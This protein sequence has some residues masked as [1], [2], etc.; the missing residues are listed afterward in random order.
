MKTHI[1]LSDETVDHII[2][3]TLTMHISWIEDNIAR[4]S[5]LKKRKAYEQQDLD[6]NKR[7]LEGLRITLRYFS[8]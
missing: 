4:L 7:N 6:D 2:V 1:E 8:P 5:K 3:E